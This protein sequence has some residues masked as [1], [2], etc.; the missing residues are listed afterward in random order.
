MSGI[1]L[2]HFNINKSSFLQLQ[3]WS[4]EIRD[5]ETIS[6]SRKSIF[7]KLFISLSFLPFIVDCTNTT[8]L[9]AYFLSHKCKDF[10]RDKK[11]HWIEESIYI[12]KQRWQNYSFWLSW[13]RTKY[14]PTE[15]SNLQNKFAKLK[16]PQR[17]SWSRVIQAC[18]QKY[19]SENNCLLQWKRGD[20]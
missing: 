6:I 16:G 5:L 14:W 18:S 8:Y 12:V 11:S 15:C 17:V 7:K 1:E 3:K 13:T 9:S 19:M 20:W 4:V 10:T 2:W